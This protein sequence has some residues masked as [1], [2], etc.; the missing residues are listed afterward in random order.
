[1]TK[2]KQL[3]AAEH[4]AKNNKTLHA[5]E[6]TKAAAAASA[7]QPK[8]VSRTAKRAP[9]KLRGLSS[10]RLRTVVIKHSIYST[11]KHTLDALR[12]VLFGYGNNIIQKALIIVDGKPA[13]DGP[14]TVTRQAIQH[15]IDIEHKQRN[16]LTLGA[17]L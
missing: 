14:A 10:G 1:M 2:S 5:K 3:R 9:A 11:A 4:V 7:A 13:G 12:A 16:G 15:A 17:V 8:G 6:G